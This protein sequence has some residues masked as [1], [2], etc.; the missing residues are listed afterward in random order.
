VKFNSNTTP[1]KSSTSPP[2]KPT[3]NGRLQKKLE[4]WKEE[5]QQPEIAVKIKG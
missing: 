5:Q 4:Q 2:E 1:S 3:K